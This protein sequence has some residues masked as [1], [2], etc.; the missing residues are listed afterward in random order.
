MS[1]LT[2]QEKSAA[3][4]ATVDTATMQQCAQPVAG[5][6]HVGLPACEAHRYCQGP[7]AWRARGFKYA[8]KSTGPGSTVRARLDFFGCANCSATKQEWAPS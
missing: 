7:H 4:C 8:D 1:R 6:D 5:K 3:Q 2:G